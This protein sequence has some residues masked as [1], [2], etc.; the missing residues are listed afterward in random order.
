MK[1]NH[2]V[3]YDREGKKQIHHV[4]GKTN[5]YR[6][7]TPITAYITIGYMSK[8]DAESLPDYNPDYDVSDIMDINGYMNGY[9]E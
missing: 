6:D 1:G 9:A 2:Y 8:A 4:T 7:S 3:Y 5:P